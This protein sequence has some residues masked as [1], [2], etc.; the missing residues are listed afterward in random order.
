MTTVLGI[1]QDQ[2]PCVVPIHPLLRLALVVAE[3]TGRRISGWRNLRWDDV[4]FQASTIR[5]RAEFDKKGFED[6]VPTSDTVQDAL[7]EARNTQ[8][9]IGTAPVFPAPKN[10]TVPC[11]RHVL[12]NWL[13]RAA[14]LAKVALEKGGLWHSLR[15]EWATERKGYPVK[16]VAAA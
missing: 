15:R 10:P 14:T 1:H 5:W 6:V 12:D 8:R 3:G 2:H 9:A 4:D 11:D 7:R 16:D 13:R